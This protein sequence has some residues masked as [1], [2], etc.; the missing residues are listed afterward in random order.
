MGGGSMA[1]EPY[2]RLPKSQFLI[3]PHIWINLRLLISTPTVK[4]CDGLKKSDFDTPGRRLGSKALVSMFAQQETV[5]EYRVPLSSF[6]CMV[7]QSLL[8][9]MSRLH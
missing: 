2:N 9:P 1:R 6:M 7:P 5:L 8:L 4:N 3:P